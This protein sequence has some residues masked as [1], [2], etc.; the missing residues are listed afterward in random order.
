MTDDLLTIIGTLYKDIN[1][2]I[3]KLV[4]A[5]LDKDSINE[6]EAILEMEHLMPS[7]LQELSY[8]KQEIKKRDWIKV[9]DRLPEV[10]E[11]V[12]CVTKK[13]KYIIA[14]TY[15]PK[16]C[17]GKILGPKEWYG[18]RSAANKITHWMH[19]VPPKED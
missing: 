4:K 7:V 16:D 5:R 19:I 6:V 10:D 18:S 13:G 14:A 15:I 12:L 11:Y 8:L 9:E 17:T 2:V 3:S 1:A